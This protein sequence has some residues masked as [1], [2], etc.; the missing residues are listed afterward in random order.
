M[1]REGDALDDLSRDELL[2]LLFKLR[3]A[4]RRAQRGDSV[5]LWK[6][7][8]SL[9]SLE[10]AIP[11][12]KVVLDYL[13]PP[14]EEYEGKRGWRE[15]CPMCGS[16]FFYSLDSVGGGPLC[17]ACHQDAQCHNMHLGWDK[18]SCVVSQSPQVLS[19]Y[20]K[21]GARAE[22][23]GWLRTMADFMELKG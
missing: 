12:L 10:D 20:T 19:L 9:R 13:D 2:A 6:A 16:R 23:A 18:S 22:V 3:L 15:L 1:A 17:L 7:V 8:A 5:Q 14:L 11:M 21:S 4:G